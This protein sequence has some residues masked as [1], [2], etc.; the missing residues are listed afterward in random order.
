MVSIVI[1]NYF[2]KEQL[3]RC[4]ESINKNKIVDFEIIVIN[5][6]PKE[7]LQGVTDDYPKAKI[8]EANNIGF[9]GGCNLGSKMARGRYLVFL[10]PDSVVSNNWLIEALLVLKKKEVGIVMSKILSL[11]GQTINSSGGII[12]YTGI[13]WSGG[14]GEKEKKTQPPYQVGFASGA[15]LFVRKDFFYDLGK[16]DDR[17][18]MY[19]EDVDLSFRARLAGKKI[20]CAPASIVYHDYEYKKGD[21]KFFYLERNRLFFIYKNYNFKMI[22]LFLPALFILELGLWFYFLSQGKILIKYRASREFFKNFKYLKKQ[23]RLIQSQKKISDYK[24]IKFFCPKIEFKE[25]NRGLVK[26]LLNPTLF[27]Y[28]KLISIFF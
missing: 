3:K 25:I 26:Y 24:I 21:Y 6:S 23:R 14:C 4:I 8:I 16:F 18:F 12:N 5:N 27:F 7:S 17:F 15:S 20:V 13:S 19:V 9:G 1:V 28:W 10:N 22:L 11:D 2:H